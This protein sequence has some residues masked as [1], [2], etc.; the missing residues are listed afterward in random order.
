ML[1]CG[2]VPPNVK[3]PSTRRVCHAPERSAP[4]SR[5]PAGDR[6]FW[7]P[8]VASN[9]CAMP[10]AGPGR[11]PGRRSR[12]TRSPC[13]C[14]P[15]QRP[16]QFLDA[17]CRFRYAGADNDRRTSGREVLRTRHSCL[18][19]PRSGTAVTCTTRSTNAQAASG[20]AR[21]QRHQ[22]CQHACAHS[23][24]AIPYP[25]E[26]PAADRFPLTACVRPFMRWTDRA[27]HRHEEWG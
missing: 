12:Q 3:K 20:S 11:T 24:R 16:R 17:G 6:F 25:P 18:A 27:C 2:T 1:P 13:F 23:G 21:P 4:G 10:P 26:D 9:V 15:R 14:G 5:A 8:A 7:S 19:S 22:P